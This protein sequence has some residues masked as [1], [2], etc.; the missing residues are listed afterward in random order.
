MSTYNDVKL[1]AEGLSDG[2]SFR[3][4]CPFCGESNVFTVTR[5]SRGAVFNCY[6]ASCIQG[7]FVSL[8]G[9]SMSDESPTA[10]EVRLAAAARAKHKGPYTG[11]LRELN[12][13]EKATLRNRVGFTDWH[14]DKSGVMYAPVDARFAYPIYAATGRRTGWVLRDYGGD[15]RTKSLTFRDTADSG[16]QSWYRGTGDLGGILVEDIPSAVR[17]ARYY[18]VAIAMNSSNVNKDVVLEIKSYTP[19]ITWAFDPDNVANAIRNHTRY[20]LMFARSK[21]LALDKDIKN[22]T[23]KELQVCV[24]VADGRVAES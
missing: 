7:G 23:E 9:G 21:V 2:E 14:L 3:G 10:R 5:D 18:G 1:I 8:H 16:I 12:D 4:T 22:M 20:S 11:T 17:A 19:Y 6:R 13:D 24:G 15:A